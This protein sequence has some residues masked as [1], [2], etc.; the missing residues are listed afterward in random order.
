MVF[1]AARQVGGFEQGIT[2]P[3]MASGGRC[4]ENKV[5]EWRGY[6]TR[7]TSLNE[8]LEDGPSVVLVHGLFSN[9]DHW[10]KNL[11]E[12]AS[13]GCRVF[14]LDLLGSGYSSKPSPRDPAAISVSGERG[15]EDVATVDDLGTAAGVS[16]RGGPFAV[17]QKHPCAGSPYNFF[18]W[19]EQ[20]VDFVEEVV[21]A[22]QSV[23]LVC[24]SIG[25][26]SGLQAAVDRPDLFSAA[27]LVAPNFRELHVAESP[28]FAVP[29]TRLVQ[30]ALREY[31]SGLFYRLANPKTV[32]NILESQPYQDK[33]QVTDE[34]VSALL[35]PLLLPGAD[36]V[37]FDSLSYSAGPLPEQ[38]LQSPNL[39]KLSVY[40]CY[41]TKDPWTPA[42]RVEA[43][44]RFSPVKKVTPIV[45]S[46]HCPMDETPHSVNNFI[47]DALR[48]EE[49]LQNA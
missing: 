39:D 37:V 27:C 45:D 13:A 19:G 18:T 2:I 43:L 23:T 25:C 15:R 46:G 41:G 35:D 48:D 26:V 1:V 20:L 28:S 4:G 49:L 12:L 34:L 21:A 17:A 38:L 16:R 14:A 6:K 31:G 9:A 7:Y 10:R 29:F 42:K 47:I 30:S 32:R 3:K 22:K 24:N 11:P 5:W 8:D 33:T 40:V 44:A 36:E